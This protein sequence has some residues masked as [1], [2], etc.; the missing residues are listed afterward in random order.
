MTD[1]T[2]K[3][4]VEGLKLDG[5]KLKHTSSGPSFRGSVRV[6][7]NLVNLRLEYLDANFAEPPKVF[8]EQPEKLSP[9]VIAHLDEAA[10]LCVLDRRLYVADRYAVAEQARGIVRRAAEVLERGLTKAGPQEIAEEFPRHWGGKVVEVH[11]GP[12]NG[13]AKVVEAKSW[14]QFEICSEPVAPPGIGAV[15][16]QT[17]LR[18]SFLNGQSRPSTLGDVLDWA[19]AWDPT[20][21]NRMLGGLSAL[22]PIDPFAIIYAPNGIAIFQLKVSSRGERVVKSVLRPRAWRTL[23]R[24]NFGRNLPITR[25]QGLRVDTEYILGTN[26]MNGTAPLAGLTIALVGCGAIGGF[27]SIALAQLGAGL[28]GGRLVLIDHDIL[29]ARNTARHR[30]GADKV[31][32]NKALACKECVEQA[33]P[34]LSVSGLPLKVEQCQ[35]RVMAAQFAIDATGEHAVGDL[36]N[37]WRLEQSASGGASPALLHVWVE[38][39]GAAVQSYFSSDPNGGCYRCLQ[40]DL[41]LPPRFPVLRRDADV[42]V[43]TG[44]GEAPFS[45]YGPAAPMAAAALATSHVLDWVRGTPRP[46]LRTARLSFQDTLERKP[47]NPSKS[48]RC[49]ACGG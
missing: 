42:S 41:L 48:N 24:G 8:V 45:P 39:N 44:C 9:G 49:P 36:L 12:R 16:I 10:E 1:A 33:F 2:L 14:L 38:G 29:S 34:G 3:R 5:F 25:N 37:A 28:A 46:L 27:L 18:L 19:R 13:F 6:R 43:A 40:P 30:L 11:F 21:P 22:S 32:T 23:V 31:G 47:A 15:V 26:S 7:E 17:G 20:L 4:L 35:S